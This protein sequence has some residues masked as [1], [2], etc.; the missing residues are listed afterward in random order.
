MFFHVKTF[1]THII[2]RFREFVCMFVIFE[3]S[4]SF[5][6]ACKT[7][8]KSFTRIRCISAESYYRYNICFHPKDVFFRDDLSYFSK[9]ML[10][11]MLLLFQQ[12]GFIVEESGCWT[13]LPAVQSFHQLKTFKIQQRRHRTA[14][15]LES[16]IRQE[17][18]N[19][20]LPKVC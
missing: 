18:D 14:E 11:H 2:K 9:I 12:H 10:N 8:R 3:A 6:H 16:E 1:N 17:W 13:D 4:G 19:I 15:Q 7:V 5:L 20:P